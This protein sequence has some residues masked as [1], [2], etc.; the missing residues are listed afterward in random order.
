LEN[1]L[2]NE[3]VIELLG[4]ATYEDLINAIEGIWYTNINH[5][6]LMV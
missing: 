2:D 6:T 1:I 3:K 4:D 5:Y